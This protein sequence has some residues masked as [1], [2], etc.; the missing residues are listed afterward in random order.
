M[1]QR[2][3]T[4]ALSFAWG[5]S[6]VCSAINLD[7]LQVIDPLAEDDPSPIAN[8]DTY[9][10]DQHDCP[11]PC[12]DIANM[13]SWITYFSVGRLRRCK[14]PMLL[15]FSVTQP[16]DDPATA[17]LIR[18][19]TLPP[20]SKP[21]AKVKVPVLS[22]NPKKSPSLYA[23]SLDTAKACFSSGTT[24]KAKLD[25]LT[26]AEAQAGAAATADNV[27]GTL[28]GLRKF[29][30]AQD[31]CDEKF[32]FAYHNQ[33]VA[34]IYIG[35]DL[36]KF[37]VASALDSLGRRLSIAPGRMVAQ[38]CSS[39]RSPDRI[40][41]IA[42][43]GTGN[44]A[45]VQ[46]AVFDWSQGVCATNEHFNPAGALEDVEVSVIADTN[47]TLVSNGTSDGSVGSVVSRLLRP[48]SR[49]GPGVPY[50]LDKRA[51]CRYTEVASGDS[52]GRLTS[53][54]GITSQDFLKYNP[55]P[56]LCSTLMPGDYVCCSAGDP[57]TKPK[58]EAPKP[59]ADGTCATHL[60]AGGD[61]CA[62]LAIK[63]GVTVADL[64]K[65]NKAKTWAWTK[66]KGMKLGYNMCISDGSAPMPPP[67]TGTECGPL[68]P[69]TLR[70]TDKTKS[71]A[72]LNPCPL[73]ACC[74]NWGFC[75]VF[76]SH[77]DIHA[78]ADSG[79]G[80]TEA[81]FATT[82]VSNCGNDIKS[83]SGPPAAFQRIGYYESWNLGRDCLWLKAK[84]A[85]TDGS[86]T[87]IHWGF[88][89]IDPTTWK[90]VINDTNKQWA[91]FK[92]LKGVKR[93]VAFGGWAYSTEKATYNI[94]RAAILQNTVVFADNIA[95]FLVDEGLDGVD[96]DWEYP[97]VSPLLLCPCS[98]CSLLRDLRV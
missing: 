15:Q 75:G 34:G 53:R 66:C 32:A 70:P 29:F 55:K 33:T 54:C 61:T 48:R 13:H 97:G 84:D 31:N 98:N 82:C 57:Y 17:V 51:V 63:Y 20:G 16:L 12:A 14:E 76:P 22:E 52:C 28:K 39:G 44:L 68:V 47:A 6:L 78:P 7:G 25:L 65:W 36:G 77:C 2:L 1:H 9:Y 69:G 30:E 5:V 83:N 23:S 88:A 56:N 27:L 4:L 8:I 60:I 38:L 73:K 35:E 40:V 85:N 10:P 24:V 93:I 96:I 92:A 86:Y 74:S 59:N 71:I 80:A 11:L 43:D 95:K 45:A 64:E 37:T 58:P 79:P 46:K 26:A 49:T 42:V 81:G 21:A 91:D 87:H 3:A 90:P 19:C 50:A 18:A 67:Q 72:D 94:I 62:S 89:E 41:G